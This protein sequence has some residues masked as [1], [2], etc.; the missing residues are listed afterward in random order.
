M[1]SF[2]KSARLDETTIETDNLNASNAELLT[3]YAHT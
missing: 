1:A 3:I 2:A